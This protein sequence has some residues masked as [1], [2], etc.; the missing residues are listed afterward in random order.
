MAGNEW[1]LAIIGAVT[2]IVTECGGGICGVDERVCDVGSRALPI[3][4]VG[5]DISLSP[6]R[7]GFE[8]RMGS[9]FLLFCIPPSHT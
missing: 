6:R 9:D 2:S 8:S 7:P 1:C 3:S 4:P 5:Q